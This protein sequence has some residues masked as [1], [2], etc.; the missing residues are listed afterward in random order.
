M[1]IRFLQYH[2]V[3]TQ[4]LIAA[5]IY[6]VTFTISLARCLYINFKK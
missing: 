4:C 6:G 1:L 3:A 5:A 2:K